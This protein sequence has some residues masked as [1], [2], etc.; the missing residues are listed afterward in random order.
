M[1]I[2]LLVLEECL[3][4]YLILVDGKSKIALKQSTI[5]NVGS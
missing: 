2:V 1:I 4:T 5:K 3:I